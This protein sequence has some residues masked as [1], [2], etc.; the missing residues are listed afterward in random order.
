MSPQL[1]LQQTWNLDNFFSGGSAS[2]SLRTFLATLKEDVS[3]LQKTL[4]HSSTLAQ[5]IEKWQEVSARLREVDSFAACLGAQDVNDQAAIQLR[6]EINSLQA[7]FD[8]ASELLGHELALL[9]DRAFSTLLKNEALIPITFGLSKRRRLA[10]EKMPFSQEA[11]LNDLSTDG[12]HGW[13]QLYDTVIGQMRIPL[14][15]DGKEKSLSVGQAS[16]RFS[17]PSRQIRKQLFTNWEAAWKEQE[18]V[19]GQILNSLAGF[20]LKIYDNR[21]WPSPLK[22]PLSLNHMEEKTLNTMWS[23]VEANKAPLL[24]YLKRKAELLGIPQLNWYDLSAPI[25]SKSGN[26]PYDEAVS[27]IAAQFQKVSPE[28]AT[29]AKSA[30]EN[31]WVEA[32]DRPGKA[33][34]GF[35]ASFPYTHETRIFMTYSNTQENVFT[36]AHELGHAYHDYVVQPQPE[37]NRNY[38][39][40]VAETASTLAE[41]VISDAALESAVEPEKQLALLDDKLQRSVLFFMNIH[42][43]FL[44]EQAF[45]AER[46]QGLITPQ[47]LCTLMEEAQKKGYCNSLASYNPY[48]WASKSHFYMTTVPFYN[49]PYA[50]GYLFSLGIYSILQRDNASFETKW[51]DIL[52]DTGSMTVEELALKHLDVDLTQPTFWQ[53]AL[54]LVNK[55]AEGFLALSHPHSK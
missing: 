13:A 36:L 11:L 5:A 37:M 7:K 35:C 23:V 53:Y 6:G 52:K 16:N 42:S 43:R 1:P 55:D 4:R 34:G 22:E 45:Y 25:G 40:S 48:F 18:Q 38:P 21:K 50:F 31:K 8:S 54:D 44:F 49:F 28:M 14:T 47:R 51:R 33:Q 10:K 20:R 24:K 46:H 19:F 3:K 15:E 9:S 30:C 39:M 27:F 17:N 2:P 12:F 41:M 29:F 32:E 26:I